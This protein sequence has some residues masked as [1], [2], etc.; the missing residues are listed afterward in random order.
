MMYI[1]NIIGDLAVGVYKLQLLAQ[2]TWLY[3]VV[4]TMSNTRY[5]LSL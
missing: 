4:F 2:D 3:N 1:L 5:T